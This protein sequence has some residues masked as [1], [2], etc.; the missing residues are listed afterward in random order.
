MLKSITNALLLIVLTIGLFSCNAQKKLARKK[1]KYMTEAYVTIK[2][3]VKEAEVT[4]LND[5]IKVLFPE[6]LLFQV[7]SA[8]IK[9]EILPIMGRF[10]K[11]LNRY[12]LTKILINGYTDNTGTDEYNNNLSEERANNAYHNL[13]NNEVPKDRL[14]K[15]GRG[16]LNPIGDNNTEEGRK[17]N[18]RVEFIILYDYAP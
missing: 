9:P 7:S 16:K 10:S 8:E 14:Y 15:W 6:H 3:Q 4:H 2:D 1:A 18:R 17:K 13:N 5:S 11:A 12:P